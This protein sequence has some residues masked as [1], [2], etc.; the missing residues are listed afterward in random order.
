MTSK[1]WRPRAGDWV[2]VCSAEDI[3][4]TLDPKGCLEH[5]PYMP[6]MLAFIGKR[7][8]ILA[9]AHKTCDTVN[10]T[11]GRSVDS[12]VHLDGLRCDGGAHGGCQAACLLFWKVDWLKP[13]DGPGPDVVAT[14]PMQGLLRALDANAAAQDAEGQTVYRCQATTLP[15]WT[16]LLPWW[17]VRQYWRDVLT[18]N[19]SWRHAVVTL[20]LATI[21]NMRRLP[22]GYRVSC[23][24]YEKAHLL[25]KGKPDPYGQ[26]KIPRGQPTPTGQL[27]LTVGEMVR[28]RS[29]KEI[30]ATVNEANFNR[31]MRIDVEMTRYC[32]EAH[33]VERR[34]TQ[35]IDEQ[36]GR[37]IHFKNPCIVL[38]GV[39]CKGDY[40]HLRLMCPR[41]ITS[42]WRELW[43]ERLPKSK[44]SS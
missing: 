18:G 27:D 9:V 2:E 44:D 43:L 10:R 1:N 36:S 5:L 29:A 20:L 21:Y 30:F 42:Y 37:M 28:I 26:G 25:L 24:L 39:D 3:A 11:G 12:V 38:D 33:R 19:V 16:K 4:R 22:I 34:V 14:P 15:A 41:R 40:S 7:F 31:G 17:D 13:V 32:G 23:W 35:I 6:E 8:R